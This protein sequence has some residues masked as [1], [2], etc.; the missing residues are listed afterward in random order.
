MAKNIRQGCKTPASPPRAANTKASSAAQDDTPVIALDLPR[1]DVSADDACR[2]SQCEDKLGFVPN[3]LAAY[4]F[5][6]AKLG[7]RR[8]R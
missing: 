5:D 2:F 3:V 8:D 4:A 1:G 6:D 7:L